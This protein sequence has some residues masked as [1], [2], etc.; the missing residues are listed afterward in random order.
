MALTTAYRD[1][2]SVVRPDIDRWFGLVRGSTYSLEAVHLFADIQATIGDTIRDALDAEGIELFDRER[3]VLDTLARFRRAAVLVQTP[4]SLDVIRADMKRALG[5]SLTRA[6]TTVTTMDLQRTRTDKLAS[7]AEAG[8]LSWTWRAHLDAKTCAYC[9]SMHGRDFAIGT[10]MLS[11]PNCRCM[12]VTGVTGVTGGW[13]WL[14]RQAIA[15]QD[16]ILHPLVAR[17]WRAGRLSPETIVDPTKMRRR[18]LRDL[19][20]HLRRSKAYPVNRRRR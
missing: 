14:R 19:L 8:A 7:Y 16:R 4:A 15:V 1:A 13:T 12:P 6:Q 9:L 18:P 20:P 5:T 11:H 10:P 3:I 2:W 17:A